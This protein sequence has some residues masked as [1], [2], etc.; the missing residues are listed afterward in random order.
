MKEREERRKPNFLKYKA[1]FSV[2]EEKN[3]LKKLKIQR[4]FKYFI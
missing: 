3:I 2:K 4:P 1:S